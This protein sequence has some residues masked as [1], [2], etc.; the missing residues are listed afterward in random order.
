MG[1]TLI[2][3]LVVISIIGILAAMSSATYS[4]YRERAYDAAVDSIIHDTIQALEAGKIDVQ[5][6]A[7]A[8]NFFWGWTDNTGTLQ[9]WGGANIVPGLKLG[10]NIRVQFSHDGWCSEGNIGAWCE[11]GWACCQSDWVMVWHCKGKTAKSWARW[12]NGETWE[13]EWAN[14]G[15]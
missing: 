6:T 2:E 14:W 12:N 9:Q 11:P 13:W 15:C 1:F 4:A 10:K 8:E 5:D 3:L 7:L